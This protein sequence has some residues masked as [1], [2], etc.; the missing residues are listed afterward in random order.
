MKWDN[1]TFD[2]RHNLPSSVK[3]PTV[4]RVGEPLE[5]C[6]F[7]CHSTHS[8]HGCGKLMTNWEWLRHGKCPMCGNRSIAGA[9]KVPLRY[10]VRFYFWSA[11]Q[12]WR[13]IGNL[14]WGWE[15]PFRV[16]FWNTLRGK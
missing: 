2:T 8:S 13:A 14:G 6:G 12:N 1:A 7:Y 4:R 3:K 10:K 5:V 15:V 16:W 11:L 9:S